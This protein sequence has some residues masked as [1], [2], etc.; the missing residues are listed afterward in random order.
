MVLA[1]VG[2]IGIQFYWIERAIEL[3]EAQFQQ[4]INNVIYDIVQKLEKREAMEGVRKHPFGKQFFHV[5]GQ[6]RHGVQWQASDDTANSGDTTGLYTLRIT[7]EETNDTV[8]GLIQNRKTIRHVL[9]NPGGMAM[10]FDPVVVDTLINNLTQARSST[11]RQR[12]SLVDEVVAEWFSSIFFK[13]INERVSAHEL[14]SIIYYELRSRGINTPYRFGVFNAKDKP[15][16]TNVCRIHNLPEYNPE[17]F[18]ARLFPNDWL[19]TPNYLVLFFPNQRGY[20]I[21]NMWFMLVASALFIVTIILV[22]IKTITTILRQK[23]LSEIK[24]D[25]I[26]NMTHELKT[27]ISTI[28][29]A[30]EALTDPDVNR[31]SEVAGNF[32]GMIR[33]ENKRL[34]VLVENALKTA[35]IDKGALTLNKKETDMAEM[36]ETVIQNIQ[37]QARNKG[38]QID[39]ER[40]GS[41][42]RISADP[43]HMA[44]VLYNLIDNA[45]KYTPRNPRVVVK[46][47]RIKHNLRIS[48]SDNGIGISRENQKKIFDKLYRIPTG[49]IHNVKGYGLGLSYV[50][51]IVEKHG[52]SIAVNSTPGK[53]ST[54][55]IQL[56]LEDGEQSEYP[57]S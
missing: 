17:A 12:S 50:K 36:A 41:E 34:G 31:N 30:C 13:D 11:V 37:I 22:F 7:E 9:E 18:Q 27:P 14:D 52:G 16:L 39:L 8:G 57:R 51:A 43:V 20:L 35:I 23:K 24:N 29:L 32:I 49:N 10:D 40:D 44:N 53:G 55:T 48:V 42:F 28:S 45:L 3:K 5:S 4:T 15:V 21:R 19:K 25:F 38:G 33:E 26:N 1:L 47:Q 46:M 56:P 54:F 6:S 2:L